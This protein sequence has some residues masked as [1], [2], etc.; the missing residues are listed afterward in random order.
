MAAAAMAAAARVLPFSDRLEA[1]RKREQ[2]LFDGNALKGLKGWIDVENSATSFSGNDIVDLPA[3]ANA[4]TTKSGGVAA[5]LSSA[6]D[7][8]VRA[9]L[10][11]SFAPDS[12]DAKSARSALARSLNKIIA[13][14][15]IYERDR[16]AGV[17]LSPETRKLVYRDPHGR[18]LVELNRNLLAETFPADLAPVKQGWTVKD[19]AMTST[20]AGRGVIYTA[21]DYARFRLT[22]TMRHV[23]GNPDHQPCVLIF[24]SR[25]SPGEVP[26]DALGGIQFQVPKGGHWDYRL[27]HNDAGGTEFTLINKVSFDP[28]E[29][30]RVEIVADATAGTARMAVTQPLG[31]NAVEV[32]DFRDPTAGRTGPVAFQMH[33]AGLFDEYK[34]VSILPAST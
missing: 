34:D 33:N 20:G 26:L 9:E 27:G 18:Q 15:L 16:F 23:S 13:G 1:E 24:C 22:F 3:L 25:P 30:S 14:P 31:G 28:H 8:S 6:L 5:F 11:A 32:L 7:D 10:S 29:W 17:N 4:I 12:P 19:G 2:V 21:H